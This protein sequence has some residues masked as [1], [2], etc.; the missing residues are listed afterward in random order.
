M[1]MIGQIGIAAQERLNAVVLAAG[2]GHLIERHVLF[3]RGDDAPRLIGE[4]INLRLRKI[5]LCNAL[6]QRAREQV[7][8]HGDGDYNGRGEGRISARAEAARA[9]LLRDMPHQLHLLFSSDCTVRNTNTPMID[10]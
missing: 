2:H 8:R 3:K 1:H 9:E 6:G 10:R 5:L 4:R 7:H